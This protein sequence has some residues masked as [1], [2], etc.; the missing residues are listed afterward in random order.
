MFERF[1][2]AARDTA[3]GAQREARRLRH[4]R[5]G[6]E[7]LLLSLLTDPHQPGAATLTRLGVTHAHC[8][9]AVAALDGPDGALAQEDAAALSSLG[10]NLDEVREKAE[11]R[12]GEGA[13]DEPAP[14]RRFGL[15]GGAREPGSGHLP[16]TATAK[17]TLRHALQE[18]VDRG[19]R[20]IGTEHVLLGLL[21]A[22]DHRTGALLRALG[23]RPD[24]LRD[25]LQADLGAK[26]S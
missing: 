8:H 18:A 2:P 9:E 19:D 21:R 6:T 5:I 25:A 15:F 14:R 16:F 7:H 1:T 10:I 23:V 13:L 17:Q 26:A 12:F 22:A 11:Q 20:T 4:D 24:A 3:V